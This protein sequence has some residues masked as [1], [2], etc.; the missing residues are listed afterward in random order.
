MPSALLTLLLKHFLSFPYPIHFKSHM[1]FHPP[2]LDKQN[3]FSRIAH[4]DEHN[5]LCCHVLL[6]III[7][8]LFSSHACALVNS[9]KW[10]WWHLNGQG[11][12]VT[13]PLWKWYSTS[14]GSCVT[15][16]TYN[17]LKTS[18]F[19]TVTVTY[20]RFQIWVFA[21]FKLLNRWWNR[22]FSKLN[23]RFWNF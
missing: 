10:R 14:R 5:G 17:K 4:K 12:R 11:V 13:W 16:S 8:R 7:N 20:S 18:R 19:V 2:W 22:F 1:P 15:Y 23:K 3:N 21:Y 6:T 9:S